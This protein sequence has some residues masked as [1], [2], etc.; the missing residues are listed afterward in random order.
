MQ[1]I[2]AQ[3]CGRLVSRT[4]DGRTLLAVVLTVL[5]VLMMRMCGAVL[6]RSSNDPLD[7]LLAVD[8]A[9]V[10]SPVSSDMDG[11]RM[12]VLTPLASC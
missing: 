8:E 5:P 6:F 2:N 9:P 1:Y 10:R 4:S 11:A 3:A 12:P 7:M